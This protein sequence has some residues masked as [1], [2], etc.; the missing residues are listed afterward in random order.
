VPQQEIL[1]ELIRRNPLTLES[2][3]KAVN[4]E[5]QERI[6][7]EMCTDKL[8]RIFIWYCSVNDNSNT[9]KMPLYK[10]LMF[11]KDSDMSKTVSNTEAELVF[12]KVIGAL[13]DK[14]LNLEEETSP[15][16]NS[17]VQ[18]LYKENE[19]KCAKMDF[20]GFYYALTII[21]KKIYPKL[22]TSKALITMIEKNVKLLEMKNNKVEKN[23]ELFKGMFEML[24]E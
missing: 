20:R 23:A 24:K 2:E 6:A 8:Q 4:L 12:A 15:L 18:R 10:F 14:R 7:V 17:K 5:E 3:E 16:K 19:A 1:T 13:N 9:N 22:S 11:L 21:A